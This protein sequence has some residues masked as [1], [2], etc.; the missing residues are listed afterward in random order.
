ME[1]KSF[2]F[3][4]LLMSIGIAAC[5]QQ[6][7]L[8]TDAARAQLVAFVDVNVVPMD[9]ERIVERQTVI[10]RDGRIVAMGPVETTDQPA[11]AQRI[12]GRGRYLMPGL[13]DMHVHL[14]QEGDL[15]LF[16][17]NGVTT[18]RNIS[19]ARFHLEWRE[20]IARGE[21]LGPTIYTTG[22]VI[23]GSPALWPGNVAPPLTA[24]RL[25][26]VE[27]R[28]EAERVVAEHHEAGYDFIKVYDNLSKDAYEGVVA[29]ARR[30][31]IPVIGHVPFGAGL[32]G[33]LVARQSSIEH[34][35]G[36]IYELF[37]D[38][39]EMTLGW[40]KRSRFLAWNHI[41][42]TRIAGLVQATLEAGIWN[43][44]TLT[45]YQKNMLPTDEHL[46]RYSRPEARYVPP[47]IVERMLRGRSFTSSGRYEAFDEAD[48][49]AGK[50]V[51]QMKKAFVKALHN[52]GAK[53]LLGTDDWF[54]GFATHE[55]LRNLVD[56]GLT[57]Y[58]VIVT[59][60]RNAA[61]FLDAHEEFGTVAV[62]KRADLILLDA[63]PLE[64]VHNIK[65]RAGVMLRGRWFPEVEL[66]QMLNRLVESYAANKNA[67][68]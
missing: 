50:R 67:E 29:A 27:T 12:N 49:E 6:A 5:G 65:K 39:S 31:G 19:G 46:R 53:I 64:D 26:V 54:G 42:T 33:V 2:A 32:D 15:L 45:R 21:L 37:P 52:A 61:E 63:N 4:F 62:G 9:S 20:K 56:A 40:D 41:D 34:L 36:Y 24:D 7:E 55:E 8:V 57:P 30:L 16:V 48:L 13:A 51:F 66:Q 60:T 25:E 22:P 35:R 44:P 17:S 58:E 68:H 3:V 14:E 28:A 38:S 47:S 10:V 59:G 23:D 18:V 11:E 43:S 1:F